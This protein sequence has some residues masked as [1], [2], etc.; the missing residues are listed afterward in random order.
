M[1]E[2]LLSSTHGNELTSQSTLSAASASSASSA[3]FLISA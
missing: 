1:G 2:E 3:L